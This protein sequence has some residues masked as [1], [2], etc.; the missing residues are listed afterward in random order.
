MDELIDAAVVEGLTRTLQA[1][2]FESAQVQAA[3][4]VLDGQRLREST[5]LTHSVVRP[6]PWV[7]AEATPLCTIVSW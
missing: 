3:I 4:H 7:R 1:C 5:T 6:P 2:G